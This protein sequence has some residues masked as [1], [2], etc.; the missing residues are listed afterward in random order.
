MRLDPS[1]QPWLL[2]AMVLRNGTRPMIGHIGF[3]GPPIEGA[4]EIGYTVFPEHRRRG[5]A[6]EAVLTLMHWSREAHGVQRFI[7]S[8]SPDNAPSLALASAMGFVR[9][10]EQMDEVD[11]LEYVFELRL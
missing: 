10:G 7:V 6:R 2:R 9:T 3:H 4:A 5:Y 11:G 8:I 1:S